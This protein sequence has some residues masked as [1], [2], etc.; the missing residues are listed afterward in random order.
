[1]L[2]TAPVS[3]LVVSGDNNLE[4]NRIKSQANYPILLT[5]PHGG[6]VKVS[7]ARKK[8]NLPSS[9]DPDQFTKDSDLFTLELTQMIAL[10][11]YRL[12][13]R[14]VYTNIALVHRRFVD[15]NRDPECAFELS[16][17]HLAQH[18]YDEYHTGIKKI[19][20]KMHNQS[21][22]G[23][24]F[25]FDIHG[26]GETDADI[27]FGTDSTNPTGS[28]ICGLLERNPNALWDDNGIMKLLQESGY[29]TIPSR[30]ND[31][32]LPSLDGGTTVKKYGGCGVNQ[33]VE[34]IQCEV[35]YE[36][37]ENDAEREKFAKDMAECILKF[38]SP[39]IILS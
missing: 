33:R 27:Y 4:D 30:V 26:T 36:L 3:I 11:L 32:E 12:G 1:M 22:Q 15:F 9:C 8:S 21:N 37:R 17:D 29:S 16:T 23:L 24:C 39:Y 5:C 34:A 2:I 25:L 7:P 28:T 35:S 20:K 38:I 31:P 14:D 10:N 19:I 13:G 18:L 6:T